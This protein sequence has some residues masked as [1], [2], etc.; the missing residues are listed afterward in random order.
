MWNSCTVA[1]QNNENI[2]QAY[3][4]NELEWFKPENALIMHYYFHKQTDVH[5]VLTGYGNRVLYW[6][7]VTNSPEPRGFFHMTGDTITSVPYS[8]PGMYVMYILDDVSTLPDIFNADMED[9]CPLV[10]QLPYGTKVIPAGFFKTSNYLRMYQGDITFPETVKTISDRA[11]NGNQMVD[12]YEFNEGLEYIG[13][14]AFYSN[15][16]TRY[17]TGL[18][19][20]STVTYIGDEAFRN[21]YFDNNTWEIG[22]NVHVLANTPPTIGENIFN[23]WITENR[24]EY[25]EPIIHVPAESVDAYKNA[26]GWS[27]YASNIVPIGDC[28]NEF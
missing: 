9:Y 19:I 25:C 27:A 8:F 22:R 18:T 20:P 11:A 7:D 10:H 24:M 21:C 17:F 16:F 14:R 13:S 12:Y 4:G 28:Y 26:A 5:K 23:G 6:A 1:Y 2:C 3:K 15:H